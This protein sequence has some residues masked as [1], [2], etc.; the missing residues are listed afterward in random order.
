MPSNAGLSTADVYR[1]ADRIGA[2]RERLDPDRVRSLASAPLEELAAALEN[3]LEQA[4]LTLRPQLAETLAAL[5]DTGAMAARITGSGPTAFGVFAERAEAEHAAA[6]FSESIVTTLAQPGQVSGAQVAAAAAAV[7]L[8]ALAIWQRRRLSGERKLIAAALVLALAVY[9]S[10]LLSHLPDPKKAIE[11]LAE[12]F[13][14]WTYALVGTMAFLETGAFVG[15]IAPGEFTVIVGG[16]VAGQGEIDLIPLLGLVWFCCIAGDTTS[17]FI[18]RRLGRSFLERHGPRVKI[19]HERLEQVD[20]YFDR[21]GGKTILIGRFVGLVRAIAPF[22]AGSSGM[23]YARFIP[24]S[25]IG[26]GLWATTFTLLGYFFWQS[27]DRVAEIAGRATLAFGVLI[28]IGAGA[29][30]AYRRL[31]TPEDRRRFAAW[32]DRQSRRPA[33]RPLAA[34][35][36]PVWRG[37]LRPVGH[38]LGPRIRFL[39]HRLTP[40][41]LGIELTTAL[42]IAA[43]RLVRVPRL[44][45]HARGRSEPDLGGPRDPQLRRADPHGRRRRH[46]EGRHGRGGHGGR[47]RVPGRRAGRARAQAPADRVRRA[48]RR[49]SLISHWLMLFTKDEV[50]RPRPAGD[51]VEVRQHA[52]PSGHATHAVVYSVL[53][54]IAARVLPGTS[55]RVALVVGALLVTAAIGASRVY[56]DVHWV[57]D[58]DRRVRARRGRVRHARRGRARHRLRA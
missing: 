56:L 25:V 5:R 14:P 40:G 41:D 57:S 30:Y 19:T 4:A 8:A 21:H 58:V 24:Y 42:A 16:V 47:S 35:A 49:G 26:T 31:R 22:I 18:G 55:S 44:R 23:P 50:A 7:A 2:T 34:V 33:L 46:R 43:R 9:A 17:F 1:E 39:W 51:I 27:F 37:V 52:Y 13:G 54:I 29:V 53:A 45:H 11:D 12:A 3:D 48:P 20:G 36:R 6:L 10:G 32:L 38:F 28:A 15:L